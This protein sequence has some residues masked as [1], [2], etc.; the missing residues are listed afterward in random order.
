MGWHLAIG[1]SHDWNGTHNY[2]KTLKRWTLI[3]D[4]ETKYRYFFHHKTVEAVVS[5]LKDVIDSI[6]NK[7]LELQPGYY[8][9]MF[10]EV[11]FKNYE[12]HL[13][14]TYV[15]L[16]EDMQDIYMYHYLSKFLTYLGTIKPDA[17]CM[18]TS[19]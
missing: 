17:M 3:N 9:R 15:W 1:D 8:R 5:K 7:Y 16:T 4:E 2:A 14:Y 13:I 12:P 6:K 19:Y 11:F 10:E 18:I